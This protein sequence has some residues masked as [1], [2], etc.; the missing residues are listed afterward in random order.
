MSSDELMKIRKKAYI[1]FYLDPGFI[2]R[3]F[4]KI[5]NKEELKNLFLQGFNY[6]KEWGFM[7][8]E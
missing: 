1:S 4:F 3:R 6:L 8:E 5:K 2:L 7:I